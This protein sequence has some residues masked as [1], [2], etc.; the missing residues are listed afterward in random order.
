MNFH[1]Q[2]L[3][4]RRVMSLEDPEIKAMSQVASALERLHTDAQERV[5]DWAWRR[6]NPRAESPAEGLPSGGSRT[7]SRRDGQDNDDREDVTFQVFVDLFDAAGPQSPAER[8]LVGGYWFQAI[9]GNPDFPSQ[10]VNT[11]LKEVGHGI[12][13]ITEAFA[14]LQERRPA[15][16]RQVAKSGRTRQARKKYKLTTAGTAAVRQ[17]LARTTDGEEAG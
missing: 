3:S 4:Q 15:L 11:E 8:A 2:H 17:M 7:R 12:D 1:H 9:Q 16:V 14:T 10:S 6:F 13:N 5:L